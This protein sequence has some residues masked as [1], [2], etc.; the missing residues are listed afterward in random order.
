MV[1]IIVE[2]REGS[3]IDRY[4][5]YSI[6]IDGRVRGVVQNRE[7]WAFDVEAGT[8]TVSIRVGQ[9]SSPPI[10]LVVEGSTRLVCHSGV[11]A[12]FGLLALTNPSD[13]ISVR[14]ETEAMAARAKP[15]RVAAPVSPQ[16]SAEVQRVLERDFPD[17]LAQ[18]AVTLVF[19]P[20]INLLNG[21]VGAVEA[22]PTW[23]HPAH[24]QV[25]AERFG[26]IAERAGLGGALFRQ[27]LRQAMGAA[28]GWPR[29]MPV[30]L[31]LTGSQFASPIL[32]QTLMTALQ[33][34]HLP[35]QRLMLQMHAQ[36]AASPADSVCHSMAAL[37]RLGVRLVLRDAAQP[38]AINAALP[39]GAGFDCVVLAASLCAA[40]TDADVR[41]RAIAPLVAAC[42]ARNI[43]C[44]ASGVTGTAELS[45][46]LE[47]GCTHGF[48]P[49]VAP[50]LPLEKV[51]A[52]L[53]RYYAVHAAAGTARE[54]ALV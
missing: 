6:I 8:H 10:K 32:V 19:Q 7:S 39:E 11:A 46:A 2:R 51:Q 29:E 5:P 27:M 54:P 23:L 1:R 17:A 26:A 44:V 50:E 42:T 37:R 53:Q 4:R 18:G 30:T 33:D 45:A 35:P 9:Y 22:R 43:P 13:W 12:A 40:I 24:G 48:G 49:A 15:A 52:F 14:E 41:G 28:A 38:G 3:L 31:L 21:Y 25:P 34:F 20:I 47:A 16:N 36:D